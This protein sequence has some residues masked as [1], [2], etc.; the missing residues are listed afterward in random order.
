MSSSDALNFF[1]SFSPLNYSA[2]LYKSHNLTQPKLGGACPPWPRQCHSLPHR[3]V[4]SPPP[5]LNMKTSLWPTSRKMDRS[6][7]TSFRHC[8]CHPPEASNLARSWLEWNAM[9]PTGYAQWGG[10][11]GD[12][13]DEEYSLPNILCTNK[14]CILNAK[15]K[16]FKGQQ[17]IRDEHQM[18][19]A[20]TVETVNEFKVYLEKLGHWT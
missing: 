6:S 2:V 16:H 10:R 5:P 11:G 15:S 17:M 14:I 20:A 13:N 19:V 4:I 1:R 18:P 8:Y 3:S 12:N 7:S 9:I